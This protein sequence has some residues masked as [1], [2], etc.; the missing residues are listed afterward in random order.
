M[1][2]GR[3][4]VPAWKEGTGDKLMVKNTPPPRRAP[5]RLWSVE[6]GSAGRHGEDR[7]G[8]NDA[9]AGI[10]GNFLCSWQGKEHEEGKT[11]RTYPVE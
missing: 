11:F 6:P 7:G 2:D 5:E 8:G 4:K 3:W 10:T 1:Q 9:E